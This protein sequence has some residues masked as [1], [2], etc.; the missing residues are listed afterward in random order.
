MVRQRSTVD[1]RVIFEEMPVWR[2][3]LKMA[4][5]TVISNLITLIYNIADTFYIA[6]TENAYM[7]AASSLVLTVF[8]FTT[9]IAN[10]FG[11]GGGTLAVRLFGKR[12]EQEARKVASLSLVIAT[13]AALLFSIVCGV[14][15]DPILTALGA[16]ENTI[17][18]ARQYLMF[19]LVI[20]G[21]PTVLSAT[22]SSIIRNL[23]YSKQAAFG[24]GLGG[25]LNVALDPLFMFVILPQGYEVIGAAVATMLSN[26]CAMVYFIIVYHKLSRESLL[27]L[28]RRVERVRSSSL[29]ELFAVGLPAAA[30][31]VLFDV[32]NMF[33]NRLTSDHGDFAL[34][35]IGIV[36][37][38]ERLP[39]NIGIG[40]ALGM[41]PL[42]A[43]NFAA[44][45]YG[46]MRAFSRTAMLWGLVVAA[47][48]ALLYR[49]GAEFIIHVFINQE[50]TASY[51]AA[52]LK[53]RCIATPFM[54]AS[55]HL[56][57]FMQAIGRGNTSLL[58]AVIRQLVL[59][60]PFLFLLNHLFGMD[61]IVW[62]QF[63]AD[64]F[65]VLASYLIYRFVMKKIVARQSEGEFA[66]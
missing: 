11:V 45:N 12:D 58:M 42:V 6:R 23:G 37:K 39:L 32:A 30:G 54:F 44:K 59:N 13:G 52:F 2:A 62:T 38:V 16:S 51:A 56:A 25:V 55:F 4:V 50:P 26:V 28:P 27:E 40:I 33:L 53:A 1:T 31:V 47:V 63:C 35:A 65:N 46:R 19:I 9:A 7:V 15:M 20:G 29:K 5:P 41:M 36:L 10:L 48:S 8:L 49:F 24:L 66:S 22:M 64:A 34:A 21:I 60:V 18:Y 3:L 61:G 43:Y 17:V 14:F 57:H